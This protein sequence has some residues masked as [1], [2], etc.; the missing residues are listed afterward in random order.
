MLATLRAPD[1]GLRRRRPGDGRGR[2][3]LDDRPGPEHGLSD[4]QR[5]AGVLGRAVA[6]GEPEQRHV[7]TGAHAG[8]PGDR[9]HDRAH[10]RH[11]PRDAVRAARTA[12]G[13]RNCTVPVSLVVPAYQQGVEA[14]ANGAYVD[15]SGDAGRLAARRTPAVELRVTRCRSSAAEPPRRHR[16]HDGRQAVQVARRARTSIA[17]TACR[18]QVPGGAAVRRAVQTEPGYSDVRRHHRGQHRRCRRTISPARSASTPR[19]A[20]VLSCR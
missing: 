6:V 7:A 11:L 19:T 4:R 14:A 10:A 16:G 2:Q 8:P 1:A 12:G 13:S 3:P 18:R 5:R 15:G 20:S 9:R 17:S